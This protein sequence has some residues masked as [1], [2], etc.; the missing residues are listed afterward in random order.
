MLL[1]CRVDLPV[2]RD[3]T[4]NSLVKYLADSYD[5]NFEMVLMCDEEI[6]P[7][8]AKELKWTLAG[9]TPQRQV[10]DLWDYIK[11]QVAEKLDHITTIRVWST[12]GRLDRH[13]CAPFNAIEF[14]PG[15][16]VILEEEEKAFERLF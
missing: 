7:V 9:P 16:Y 11:S 12:Y 15:Y 13:T 3:Y 8:L 14:H 1:A 5:F 2:A 4:P 6:A 10:S